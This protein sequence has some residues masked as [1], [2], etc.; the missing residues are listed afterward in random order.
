MGN[1]LSPQDMALYRACDEVLHYVWDPIGVATAPQARDE[2]YSY[3]P[4]VFQMVRDGRSEEEVAKYLT[5]ITTVQ[6][7]LD[8]AHSHD[9]D[10]ARL[11]LEWKDVVDE[12][13]A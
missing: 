8:E 12:K 11:L 1:K 10:V 9:L 2:Y 13:Y 7:G 4:L 3:L 6:M 5:Q